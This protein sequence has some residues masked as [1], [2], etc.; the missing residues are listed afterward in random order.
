MNANPLC[1]LAAGALLLAACTSTPPPPPATPLENTQWRLTDLD[2]GKALEGTTLRLDAKDIQAQGNSGCNAYFGRYELDGRALRFGPVAI[3]R[4]ACADREMNRQEGLFLQAL[5]ATRGW[6]V[7]GSTLTLV[8]EGGELA[9][10][11]P[12][13]RK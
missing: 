9:R 10:F 8:G 7:E 5:G 1:R 13:P 12:L 2:G 11:A 4:R 3:S 6:R